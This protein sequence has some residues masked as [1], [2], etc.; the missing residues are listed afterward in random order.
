MITL[1]NSLS[2]RLRRELLTKIDDLAAKHGQYHGLTRSD[3][4]RLALERGLLILGN[5]L[6]P[7][8]TPTRKT[9]S[10]KS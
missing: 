1:P 4:I 5:E 7:P 9:R 6:E 8:K 3:V 2:L 10:K